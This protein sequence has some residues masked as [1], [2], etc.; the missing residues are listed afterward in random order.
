MKK[1]S[2][3][4]DAPKHN[5]ALMKI[6]TYEKA[7]GNEVKLNMPLWKADFTYASYIFE[8]GIRFQADEIGG[9]AINPKT[10]L[11][12]KIEKLKPDYSLFNLKHS[13][14]Y[15]FRACFRK[16][17]FC[18]VSLL[19]GDKTHHSIWD[20]YDPKFKTIELLNNNTFFDADWE[21]TFWEIDQLKLRVIDNGND[22]RLLDDHRTWWVKRL[23]WKTQPK[24]AWDRMK[25]EKKII[26][27]L[28]LLQ[29]HKVNAMVYVLMGYDTNE[30]QDIYR[31]E[32]IN[33][34]GLD[35][36]PM[37]YKPTKQLRKFRRMIYLRYYRKYKTITKAWK[38]YK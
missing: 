26:E 29:K 18:K 19:S 5:L 28:K 33:S 37:L 14:G 8:G 21:H 6:S 11:P 17:P 20:F 9:I 23:R 2:L 30:E 7:R 16:C 22:L 12:K 35:P 27:G 4:T 24:F 10:V 15:T 1:I 32:I 25:D 34:F 38:D 31:C 36:F 13:L 3:L